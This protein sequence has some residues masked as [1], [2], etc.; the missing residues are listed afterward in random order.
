MELFW[1]IKNK[2]SSDERV[3]GHGYLEAPFFSLLASFTI[4]DMLELMK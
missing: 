2:N 4:D 3:L 1:G